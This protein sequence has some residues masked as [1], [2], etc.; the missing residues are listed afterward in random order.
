[1][2]RIEAWTCPTCGRKATSAF[3]PGCGEQ[4]LRP[5]DLKLRGLLSELLKAF[6]KV[7]GRML[8]SF[9]TLLRFPGALTVAFVRGQRKPYLV[10]FQLFLLANVLF[11]AVQ[12][13]TDTHVFSSTLDSHLHHQD[14]SP[15]AERLV[16]RRLEATQ[17]SLED[18]APVFDRAVMPRAKALILLMV[19]PFT[20]A[21]ALLFRRE[22]PTLVTHVV[23]AVHQYSFLLVAFSAALV[24]AWFDV[25]AGGAGLES[26]QVDTLLSLINLAA[27]FAYLQRATRVVYGGTEASRLLKNLTLTLTV[28]G[29]ALGYRFALLLITLYGT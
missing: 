8:R 6:S 10:P 3:C 15:L 29:I 1:L 20:A 12:S 11:V 16:A 2:A 28:A 22:C 18:Y 13:F 24:F 25:L 17:R 23:F 27:C 26:P 7:D 5:R 4:A 9:R 21:L 14:W 19:F